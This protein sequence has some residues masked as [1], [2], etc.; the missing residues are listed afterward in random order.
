MHRRLRII[1]TALD[2]QS[3][4]RSSPTRSPLSGMITPNELKKPHKKSIRQVALESRQRLASERESDPARTILPPSFRRRTVKLWGHKPEKLGMVADAT[5]LDR[6][7]PF[8]WIRGQAIGRG[9]HG[10]VYLSLNATT[11]E[12]MAVK[13]ISFPQNS[14]E[15][16][17]RPS[18]RTLKREFENMKALRHPNLIE[19]LGLEEG[20]D[21]FSL[22]M[23]YVPG[24]SI[25]TNVQTDGALDANVVKSYTS[26]ILDGLI[27]LH[28]R[29]LIHGALKSSN[30]LVEPTGT[31][32]IEGLVCPETEVRDNSRAVPRAIFWMAPEI[33]RTQYK[34]YDRKAD[35]W[36]LG[37]IVLEML[38]GKRPWFNMEAVAVMFKASHLDLVLPH[39]PG[40]LALDSGATDLM[41]KCLALK[42]EDRSSAVQLRQHPY[43]VPSLASSQTGLI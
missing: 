6:P 36:S 20:G 39:P 3:P 12:M 32:K 29:G 8:K 14:G 10:R 1:T 17:G 11:G 18:T 34:V 15:S 33:I 35:I 40:D 2:K 19:Y 21:L 9:T 13:Q 23:K 38:T 5:R 16:P 31:C 42:P 27:Y 43:L 37:C 30:I 25:R 28:A 26:Q 41:E 4:S 22:F 7:R 24:G